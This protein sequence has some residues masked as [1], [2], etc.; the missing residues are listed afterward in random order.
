MDVVLRTENLRKAYGS[1]SEAVVALAGVSLRVARGEFVALMGASGSCKSTLLHLVAGLDVVTSG[2]ILIGDQNI[3]AL[4]DARRT[5]FRRQ[6]IGLVFQAYNLLPTLTALENVELPAL[7]DGRGHADVGRRAAELLDMLGLTTRARHRPQAMS[8][9]ERQRVAIARALINDP[10]LLLA[11]EP[12]GN[13]GAHHSA[14]VWREL[15]RL[16]HDQGRTVVAVTHEATGATFADRV[17]VLK[18]GQILGEIEPG[19][20]GHASL[21][22][23]RYTELV[24]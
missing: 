19:G 20:E 6:N 24:S 10:L 22:A 4:S 23:A 1:A 12:T 7:L 16:V 14:S 17:I 11:D 8:G 15:R 3:G 2:T 18:D 5:L 13:L 9:G 21:V